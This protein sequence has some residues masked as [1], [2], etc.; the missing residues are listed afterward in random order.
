M[1]IVQ[2]ENGFV[3]WDASRDVPDLDWAASHYAPNI[4][5]VEAPDY[6][7]EGWTYDET[8]EGDDRFVRPIAPDGWVYD[9]KTGSFKPE[10]FEEEPSIDPV[11]E[12]AL[13]I[14]DNI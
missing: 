11:A 1:K 6:V 5:F 4:L 7:F 9:D 13:N 14:L 2:I 3:H 8:A 10:G 12:M